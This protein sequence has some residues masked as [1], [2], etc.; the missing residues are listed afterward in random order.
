[1]QVEAFLMA[2]QGSA[3]RSLLLIRRCRPG[4]EDVPNVVEVR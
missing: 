2:G 1:M 3:A 4:P